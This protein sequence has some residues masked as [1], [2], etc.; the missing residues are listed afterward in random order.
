[1]T[2]QA[3]TTEKP[4]GIKGISNFLNS[5]SIKQKFTEVMGDNAGAF[6]ASILAAC[7]Q[8]DKLKLATTESIYTAALMAAT[9][10]LP[11]NSNLGLSFLIP[12]TKNAGKPNEVTECQF[13]IGAKG[14]KQL[15]LRTGQY[16]L[17]TDAIVYEGQLI[18]QN[19]LTGFKFD[20]NKKG[21]K[22]I[23]YVSYIKLNNGY[24]NT[25][26][27]SVEEM[28]KH[29]RPKMEKAEKKHHKKESSSHEK[30]EMKRLKELEKMHQKHMADH[31]K[32]HMK[33]HGHKKASKGK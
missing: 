8:N 18:E 4:K 25:L 22:I 24:E 19:P 30:S 11:I 2:V 33:H 5:E 21:T 10:N 9:L 20:W 3:T 17:I 12:Y 28:E 13:Q 14:F 23:G 32:H 29:A 7:N 16:H 6:I 15:A 26:Y 1:M 27:M 31:H